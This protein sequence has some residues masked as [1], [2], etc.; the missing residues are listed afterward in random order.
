MHDENLGRGREEPARL[1]GERAKNLF[2]TGQ[3]LCSEAVLTVINRGLGGGLPDE[4]AIRLGSALAQGIG[5]SG[6]VCGALNG[7]ALALGLHLGRDSP[8]IRN[9][10][11]AMDSA[12][13]LHDR[14]KALFGATCCRV[15][16]R[17]VKHD[18]KAH[19]QQC[20]EFTGKAAE[21]AAS[22]ILEKH[23]GLLDRADWDYLRKRDSRMG[24][25]LKRLFGM[26]ES[27]RDRL[28]YQEVEPPS[29]KDTK[30]K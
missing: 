3:L 28:T 13:S 5:D 6:C 24:S 23:A 8:G 19:A 9:G 22:L 4:M 2:E 16:T 27:N 29:H 12:G 7:A 18:P 10:R 30:K 25:K 11:N 26:A 21:L 1:I 20:A 15:L 17:K 14:F